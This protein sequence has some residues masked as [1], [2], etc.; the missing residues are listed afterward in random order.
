MNKENELLEKTKLLR[1]LE[2]E[3]NNKILKS[4][5]KVKKLRKTRV[6]K[7]KVGPAPVAVQ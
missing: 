6:A 2:S 1:E 3:I 7:P 5:E 4:Q